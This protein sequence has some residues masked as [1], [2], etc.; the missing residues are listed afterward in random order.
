MNLCLPLAWLANKKGKRMWKK[1]NEIRR[2]YL[3][4]T[5]EDQRRHP[6]SALS[7]AAVVL[8]NKNMFSYPSRSISLSHLFTVISQ[9]LSSLRSSDHNHTEEESITQSG[10]FYDRH[11]VFVLPG[12]RRMSRALVD[13]LKIS[14]M[15]N[16]MKRRKYRRRE[17]EVQAR[18]KKI[19][20]IF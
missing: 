13:G 1:S 20:D 16:S 11:A 2:K 10:I 9:G 14:K 7:M 5:K 4:K 3:L 12:W 6:R 19:F 8:W 15:N 17:S 18:E